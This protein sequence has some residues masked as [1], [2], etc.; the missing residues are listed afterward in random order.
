MLKS[1]NKLS[2]HIGSE[3]G[4]KNFSFSQL[5]LEVKRLFD[6]EGVPGFVK[7]LVILVESMLIKSGVDCPG[8]KSNKLQ[9]HGNGSKKMKTSIGCVD[10]VLSRMKCRSCKKTFMPMMRLFDVDRYSRKSR[11]FEKLTLETVTNQSFR[12]SAKNLN[13][14]MGFSGLLKLMLF[15]ML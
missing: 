1:S 10:L 11:E 8:C 4:L 15:H 6:V 2:L 3:I 9:L 13:D 14:T 5:I 7:M 12:R